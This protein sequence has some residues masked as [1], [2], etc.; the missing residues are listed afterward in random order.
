MVHENF[1]LYKGLLVDDTLSVIVSS[2][3]LMAELRGNCRETRNRERERRLRGRE[4]E[5]EGGGDGM[6]PIHSATP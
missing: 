1:E 6:T 2:S 4:G 3:L 5:R